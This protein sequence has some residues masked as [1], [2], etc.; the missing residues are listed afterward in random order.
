MSEFRLLVLAHLSR[1]FY[2]ALLESQIPA[3]TLGQELEEAALKGVCGA[4]SETPLT[5]Q[6]RR[7]FAGCEG[8]PAASYHSPV[9]LPVL[10]ED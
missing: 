9:V 4:S 1:R 2:L 7:Q 3:G 10:V 6:S 5:W 8:M